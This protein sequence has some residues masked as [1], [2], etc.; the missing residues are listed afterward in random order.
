LGQALKGESTTRETNL[1]SSKNI[2]RLNIEH[3]RRLLATET[4]PAKRVMIEKL[5]A[6]EEAKLRALEAD[7]KPD[8]SA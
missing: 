1:D 7:Q 5:L 2:A 3:Y 4:D 6:E 8:R